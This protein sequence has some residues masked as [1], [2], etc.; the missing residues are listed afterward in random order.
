MTKPGGLSLAAV[1]GV[2]PEATSSVGRHGGLFR[3]VHS[4]RRY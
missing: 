4:F 2:V 1:F 3:D